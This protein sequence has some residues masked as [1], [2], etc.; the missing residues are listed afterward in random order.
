MLRPAR[1]RRTPPVSVRLAWRNLGAGDIGGRGARLRCV[2][3]R[4][5]GG[6]VHGGSDALVAAAATDLAR[7]RGVDRGV[8]GSRITIKQRCGHEDHP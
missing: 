8:A 6:P 5:D 3:T 1:Q 7:K 2:V 4:Q